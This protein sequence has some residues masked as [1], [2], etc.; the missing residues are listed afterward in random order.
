MYKSGYRNHYTSTFTNTVN[1]IEYCYK[2]EQPNHRQAGGENMIQQ[3]ETSQLIRQISNLVAS[4]TGFFGASR[5]SS[6]Q[7]DQDLIDS[8]SADF[9]TKEPFSGGY[10]EAFVIQFWASYNPR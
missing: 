6:I 5:Y 4:V 1:E 2:P 7:A 8:N 10:N 9:H 3:T